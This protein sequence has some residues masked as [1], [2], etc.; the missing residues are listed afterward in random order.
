MLMVMRTGSLNFLHFQLCPVNVRGASIV[1]QRVWV[2]PIS[3]NF[4]L[5]KIAIIIIIISDQCCC[6]C[7]ECEHLEK[8]L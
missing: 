4:G 2:A 6:Y 1:L 3:T 7:W 5:L 8:I